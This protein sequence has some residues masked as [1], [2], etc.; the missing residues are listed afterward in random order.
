[1]DELEDLIGKSIDA[2]D[3][4]IILWRSALVIA[5]EVV[6]ELRTLNGHGDIQETPKEYP[7]HAAPDTREQRMNNVVTRTLTD[8]IEKNGLGLVEEHQRLRGLLNDYHPTCKREIGVIVH[9][10]QHGIPARLRRS[11]LTGVV[12]TPPLA[13]VLH[14]EL[15][16]DYEYALWAV[17]AWAKA[18]LIRWQA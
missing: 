11:S 14:D 4:E 9:A 2:I 1:M 3:E 15:G 6:E 7:T 17:R 16:M 8:L 5:H 10:A 18:L 12:V 13:R